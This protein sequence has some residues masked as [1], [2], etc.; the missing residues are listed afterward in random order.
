MYGALVNKG[1]EPADNDWEEL[2]N[3]SKIKLDGS[4]C[5]VDIVPDTANGTPADSDSGMKGV[6]MTISSNLTLN[7]TPK[8]R[9]HIWSQYPLPMIRDEL[10]SAIHCRSEFI[11]E[12]KLLQNVSK[13]ENFTKYDSGLYAWDIMEPWAISEIGTNVEGEE[14]SVGVPPGV[15]SLVRFRRERYILAIWNTI[16]R[17]RR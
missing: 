8:D 5:K 6:Y 9:G 1:T 17:G 3:L 2:D 13:E 10:Q 14:E 7:G 16:C 12:M 4:K 11:Q 15:R